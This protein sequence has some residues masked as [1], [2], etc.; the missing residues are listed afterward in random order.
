MPMTSRPGRPYPLGA[1]WDGEGVNFAL[2]AGSATAVELCLF[3][4]A[5]A[6]VERTR[7]PA[8]HCTDGVWHLRLPEARPGQLY[9]Y[10]VHGSWEPANGHRHNP[11]KLL[12]DPYATELGRQL[13]W[14]D[15]LCDTPRGGGGPD[16]R[17]TA[18]WAPLGRVTD[19][20]FDWGDDRP[21]RHDWADTVIYELHV[22]GFTRRH[23]DVSA[24]LRGRFLGLASGAALGHLRRLGVTAIELLPVHQHAS[25]RAL[26]GRGLTNYWG[27]NTLAYFA[28][29]LRYATTPDAA[30]REFKT[31]V[32]A[33]H[34]AGIEV[35]LDVVFNHTAEGGRHGP[36]VS[37]RGLDNRAY[38]RLAAHDPA[39]YDDVTGCGNTLDLSHPRTLQLVLDSLRYWV[40]EMRV[41]GFRFD[42]A[43]ALAREPW[44]VDMGCGFL[45]ALRQD[46]VLSQVKLV[47]EPWDLG[48]GGHCTGRF[49]PPFREWNDR[50]R[51]AV[52]RFWRAD[53][54]QVP[55]FATRLAGSSDLFGGTPPRPGASVNFVTAHDG[56]TLADLVAYE[57]KRNMANG[58]RNR[59]GAADNLSWNCGWEGPS[60]DPVVLDRRARMR[61]SLLA[62]LVLSQGVPMLLAGD[63]LGRTQ[64]GNNNA[65]C[66][67]NET[68]WLD[69]SPARRDRDLETFT[70]RLLAF[71][72]AHPALRRRGFLHGRRGPDEAMPDLLWYGPDGRELGAQDWHRPDL[73]SVGMRLAGDAID[74]RDDDGRVVRDDTLLLLFNAADT[75]VRF[76]LPPGGGAPWRLA[77]DTAEPAATDQDVVGGSYLV[78][79]RTVVVLLS[80]VE[81]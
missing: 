58:E 41:D 79:D 26:R 81:P 46:P 48:P 18:R 53:L 67:D 73:A 59:D 31:M 34:A 44:G 56:F 57:R 51:D 35:L 50:Y 64:G 40:C 68:S 28:P 77:L 78:R 29:D 69:W 60:D 43:P 38:Y 9:G 1:T 7:V 11:A 13:S 23:P 10:R 14:H 3:D 74:E 24:A 72:A 45:D 5:D 61:R 62:T 19:R 66:Q 4:R 27:Y 52:R 80:A 6:I 70:A 30:V 25:E 76:R 63:E 42:L 2:F 49:P 12:L 33:A 15:A 32:R 65:Y 54:H 21:P 37:W 22:G 36:T 47:A 17:D 20:E 16:P 71:R 75:A 55:E 39:D 8:E